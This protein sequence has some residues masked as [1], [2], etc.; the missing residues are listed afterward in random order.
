MKI[1]NI[2]YPA[3]SAASNVTSVP[4]DLGDLQTYSVAVDFSGSNV[5][6]T[7]TL[8]SLN[9]KDNGDWVTVTSSSQAVTSSASHVWNVT[10][11]GYRW[12]RV[13]WVASSGTGNISAQLIAKE[14]VLKG[15]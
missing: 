9:D 8:E 6:G 15:G 1:V 5:A 13:K 4:F 3:T 12:V 7:L 11:A 10:G 14:T 2:I